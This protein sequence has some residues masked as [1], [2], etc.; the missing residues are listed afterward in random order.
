MSRAIFLLLTLAISI[1]SGQDSRGSIAGLVTDQQAAVLAGASVAIT[2]VETGRIHRTSTNEAGIFE[3]SFL[4]PGVYSI[5]VEAPGFRRM[6]RGNLTVSVGSRLD[7]ALSMEIGLVSESIEVNEK[8]PLLDTAS[9]GGG[10][11]IDQ[12]QMLQL[13]IA[14][15]NPFTLAALA[16]G[17]QWTGNPG[18]RRPSDVGGTSAFNTAGGVGQNEYT[19]DGTPVTG[20]GRRVGFVPPSDAVSEF[21]LE[22][23]NFDASYGHST[24]A[25]VNVATKSGTNSYHGTLY[26]QHWQQRWN[27]TPHF[28]RLAF[29]DQVRSGRRSAGDQ[30]QN[31]GR[32]NFLGG[33][34]G[35]P[36]LV[37]KLYNGKDKLFF[38]LSYN[39]HFE[40]TWD[41]DTPNRTVPKTAWRDGDFSDLLAID[42][43][44]FTVYDP[45]SARLVN[46]RVVRTPFPGNRGVPVLNPIYNYYASLYPK[47]NDVPG[48]VSPEGFNNY[49]ADKTVN[50][51]RYNALVNRFDYNINDLHHV[52]ARWQY[53]RRT[54]N[55]RDWAYETK[56]GLLAVGTHRV[57]KGAAG[58]Y[59]WTVSSRT[60]LDAHVSWA[61]F[62]EGSRNDIRNAVKPSDVGLPEYLDR[63][64]GAYSTLPTV[65][66]S[67][68]ETISTTYPTLSASGTIG[69]ARLGLTTLKGSHSFKYGFT[70]RRYWYASADPGYSAGQFIFNNTYTRQADDTNT[71]SQH[72]LEWAA[73]RMGLPSAMNLDIADTA[74]WSTRIRSLYLQD[75]WRLSNRFRLNFGLRYEREGGI[76]ERFNRGMSGEFLPDA[77]LPFSDIAQSVYARNPI[78]ELP[79]SQFRVAGGVGYLGQPNRTY[80]DGTHRF[81]PRIGAV[82]ELNSATVLRVGYGWYFDT[83]NANNTQPSQFGYSLPTGAVITTDN[84]LSF[85]GVGPAGDLSSNRNPVADPFP[86]GPGG[87]R[88]NQPYGNRLGVAARAGNSQT[89]FAR[90]Y[91]PA[92]Q[93]RWKL[94]V[95]RQLQ[96]DIVLEVSYNGSFSRIPV[97][98]PINFLAQ[99]YWA[100]GN[101]RN[102][103]R[104]TDL[105]QNLPNPFRVSNLSSLASSD[106]QLYQHL[107]S[108]S[109]FTS[110]N[111]RKNQ[112]LR[113][114]PHMTT[115]NGLRPGSDFGDTMGGNWYHDAQIL[116]EKRFSRG[117][118]S[119]VMYTYAASAVQDVYFNEFDVAPSWQVNNNIRPH[120]FVWSGIYEMPFGKG[121][122]WFQ[123]GLA[124]HLAGGWQLSW[125]YQYQSGAATQWAN[126]FFY[127]DLSAIDSL[128]RSSEVH[129]KDIHVWFDPSIAYRGTGAIPSGFQGFEGRAAQQPGQFHVRAFPTRL[130]SLR[131][132]GIRNWD[133][134]ILRK[135]EVTE[136]V[137]ANLSLDLLNATN[138][139]NFTAPNLDPTNNNFGRVTAQNGLSRR[140]QLNLRI[141]F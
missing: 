118:Q 76:T 107:N 11:V 95:Q 125:V 70:E 17:M 120:R 113:P 4:D 32:S 8:P 35:G 93:Q 141:D 100:T 73:F 1:T 78:A 116:L 54:P 75:D 117:L 114:Y 112:L 59:V 108:L 121:R 130:D 65:Q 109:F 40:N 6:V 97:N 46:G 2:N 135:F 132:D 44:R 74:Y 90:D 13:P 27:A 25:A 85:T 110:A 10:R 139:T 29:E 26:D 16:P 18:F 15:M 63:Q 3:A 82:M 77:K 30:K 127:G 138:H 53:S 42:A 94:G 37:P 71:A 49:F 103:A 58:N 126:R 79:A 128:L 51:L 124:K 86:A 133:V 81:L 12:R 69:E 119:S 61:R 38:F 7:L 41:A 19:I 80:T 67:N 24:G 47:P 9:V 92:S 34:F 88:F 87:T 48:L 101:V 5:S 140:L 104:D 64:A 33:N 83:L 134:K 111:I 50:T 62:A 57:N 98:Q 28:T 129:S 131:T 45:R 36:V 21:K 99:Q 89:F 72:G 137:A 66:F 102:N 39:G 68:L 56:P 84:G 136:R 91:R 96:T 14:D 43:T 20:T 122:T 31:S 105:N 23:T 22:T 55:T 60:V 115:L 52:S 123:K 106:P